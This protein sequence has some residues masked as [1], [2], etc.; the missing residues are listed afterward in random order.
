MAAK[1]SEKNRCRCRKVT[2]TGTTTACY[3]HIGHQLETNLHGHVR[4]QP[5]RGLL[6]MQL[7]RCKRTAP[8]R[9]TEQ[10]QFCRPRR[11]GEVTLRSDATSHAVR[12]W[13]KQL[14]RIQSLR[15]SLTRGSGHW[16]AQLHRCELWS[17]ILRAQGFEGGFRRFWSRGYP[18]GHPHEPA[19]LPECLPTLAHI[20]LIFATFRQRFEAFESWHIRQ[21][22]RLLKQKHD[23]TMSGLF[24]EHRK[25]PK[26]KPDLLWLDHYYTVLGIDAP[27]C[28]LHLD[29]PLELAGRSTWTLNGRRIFVLDSE[30]DTCIVSH[31][32]PLTPGDELHQH[33]VLSQIDEV[34]SAFVDFWRPRWNAYKDVSATDWARVTAFAQ[35]HMRPLSF[36]LPPIDHDSWQRYLRRY[37]PTAA[38]GVDGLSHLDFINMPPLLEKQALDLLGRVE[39]GEPW[40]QQTRFGVVQALAKVE[41][42]HEVS[43]FR[44]I[45]VLSLLYRTWGSIRSRQLLARLTPHLPDGQI[46]FVPGQ[47][48]MSI[49][50]LWTAMVDLSCQGGVALCGLSSDLVRAFNCIPGEPLLW[51]ASFLGIP[52]FVVTPWRNYLHS[53]SRSFMIRGALSEASLSTV[54]LPEGCALSVLGMCLLDN[55]WHCYQAV[56]CPGI[57]AFS[58]VDNLG[59]TARDA[60]MLALGF[61]SMQ[62]FFTLWHMEID[63]DKSYCWATDAVSRRALSAFPMKA[64]THSCELGGSLTFGAKPSV[65]D[66]KARMQRLDRKWAILARSMASQYQKLTALAVSFWP[67][68]L[69][70]A[71]ACR[72]A[73]HHLAGLRRRAAQALGWRLAGSSPA[74][75]FLF[76]PMPF[77]DPLLWHH[78]TVLQGFRRLCSSSDDFVAQWKL[79]RHNYDGS[80]YSGPYSK[81]LDLCAHLGWSFEA[82]FW[83]RDHR[84]HR[85]HLLYTPWAEVE[86]LLWEAWACPG[87]P[88][89]QAT[90]DS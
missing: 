22:C 7:G 45:V 76:S 72:F 19:E 16:E 42:A 37:K 52:A 58:Y 48:A 69:H 6:P 63:L 14:R 5:G 18:D 36:E 61:A 12:S 10:P 11:E 78:K 57:R 77:A 31:L 64:A 30:D 87:L 24:G 41:G 29:R 8:D 35:A 4:T 13:F 32:P 73:L 88:A 51:L 47:E 20:E 71:L 80:L 84:G 25:V 75:R 79:F 17:A 55:M 59:L 33:Q 70:G 38:R 60:G 2:V 40:P 85:W 54:G 3:A 74:M 23:A 86:E 65:A 44:P 34:H 21:R 67:E 62:A 9:H 49:W 50:A 28:A 66:L 89:V 68:G 26:S 39:S 46:G 27:T 56:L 83:L 82:D 53:F 1:R 81:M 15:Q 90:E 43:T